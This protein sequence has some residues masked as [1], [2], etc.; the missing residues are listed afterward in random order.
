MVW[1]FPS[2]RVYSRNRPNAPR[3]SLSGR[4]IED[5]PQSAF[6]WQDLDT[7]DLLAYDFDFV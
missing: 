7:E 3:N 4:V 5:C 6:A 2:L 1:A